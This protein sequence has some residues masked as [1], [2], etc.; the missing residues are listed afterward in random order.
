MSQ[1]YPDVVRA[2]HAE[3]FSAIESKYRN[4]LLLEGDSS[5][6]RFGSFKYPTSEKTT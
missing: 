4:R 5:E 2:C 3:R 1:P 6:I